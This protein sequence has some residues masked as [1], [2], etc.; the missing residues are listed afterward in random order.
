MLSFAGVIYEM[1]YHENA[2]LWT[3]VWFWRIEPV[4]DEVLDGVGEEATSGTKG[5]GGGVGPIGKRNN[6]LV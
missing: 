5:G 2:P 4:E 1:K 3:V 6:S